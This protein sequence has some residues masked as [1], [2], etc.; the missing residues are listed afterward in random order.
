MFEGDCWVCKYI[1]DA[2][3]VFIEY[4][5]SRVCIFVLSYHLFLECVFV[6]IWI[7]F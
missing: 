6:R 5:C 1:V 3:E 4:S 7:R 2:T